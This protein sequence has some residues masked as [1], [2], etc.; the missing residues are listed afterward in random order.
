VFPANA[1]ATGKYMKLIDQA[2][3]LSRIFC[4]QDLPLES[5]ADVR[6]FFPAMER[7]R[8]VA[9]LP[10]E[11]GD[12]AIGGFLICSRT[13]LDLDAHYIGLLEML[14]KSVGQRIDSRQRAL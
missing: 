9:S 11:S 6:D 1:E 10:V 13:Q 7:I 2:T 8:A 12:D 14:A 4:H 5:N 3:S